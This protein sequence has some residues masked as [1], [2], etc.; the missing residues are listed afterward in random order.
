MSEAV[1]KSR[2]LYTKYIGP[3]QI[4]ITYSYDCDP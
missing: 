3:C 1:T 2:D 4:K